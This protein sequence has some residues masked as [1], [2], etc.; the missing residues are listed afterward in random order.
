MTLNDQVYAQAMTLAGDLTENQM[1]LPYQ[2]VYDDE[3]TLDAFNTYLQIFPLDNGDSVLDEN[4]TYTTQ[5][6]DGVSEITVRRNL[7]VHID[8]CGK[9]QTVEASAGTVKG[10]AGAAGYRPGR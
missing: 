10:T 5:G 1:E 7:T 4:D 9:E 3:W 6:G 8:N 2:K